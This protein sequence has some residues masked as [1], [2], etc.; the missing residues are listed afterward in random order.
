MSDKMRLMTS[1]A[2]LVLGL[3]L[4][5]VAHAQDI[6]PQSAQTDTDEQGSSEIVVSGLRA[7]LQS[8]ASTK[9]NSNQIQDSILAEDIGK[10]PDTNIAETLQRIPGV[11]ISRNTRGEGNS[12]VIHGLKQVMTTVN[13]RQLFG[14][15]NRTA[16]LLDYSAD[17][18]SGVDVYKTATS[19]QIEGGLGG[20]VNI[21]TARPFDFDGMHVA[22]TGSLAYS[23]FQDKV[24]PRISGVVS[25]RW[26][27]GGG[28]FG[29]LVGGQYERY[30]SG[31][32]QSSTNGYSDNVNLFDVDES[33]ATGTAGDVVTV[34]GQVRMRYETG[35]R[36]R[37]ALYG[38]AQWAPNDALTIHADAI[39]TYSGGHSFT[40][41]MAVNNSGATGVGDPVFK[42]GSTVLS[43]YSLSNVGIQ[44]AVGAADNPYDTIN[45]ALG[46]TYQSGPWTISAE[47]SYVRSEGPFYYRNGALSGRAPGADISLD[48]DTPNV[49]V[50][51]ID[52][53]DP[54]SYTSSSY[55][56]YGTQQL[57]R[58]PSFRAD[59]A[60]D[61]D[62]GPI[63][64]LM[65]GV[66]WAEHRAI[67]D[68]YFVNGG[69]ITQSISDVTGPTP[70][71][72]FTNQTAWLNQWLS[73]DDGIFKDA[74]QAR[75][76]FGLASAD[77]AVSA[78]SHYDYTETT[79]AAY[80]QAQYALNLGGLPI[81]GNI[82][83]RYVRTDG[84]QTVLVQNDEGDYEPLSGGS[85]YEDWLPSVNM[86]LK[87]TPDLF[88]RLAFSKAITRPDYG[89]LS[90][91]VLLNP[92]SLTGSGGNTELL[93]T[94]ADQYDLSLEYYF[95][96]L[97]YLS[98]GLFQKDVSGFIQKFYEDET[99]DG[100]VYQITRPR[101]SG[102]GRIRGFEIAYQQFFDFL[103]GMLSGLGFQGNYTY[104]DS[105]LEQYGIPGTVPA[106]Q[107]SKHAY[108]LTGIYEKG[109]VSLHVS[110]NWRSKSVQTNS[111]A[112]NG[113]VWNAPQESLDISGTFYLTD[114]LSVKV[115][116]VNA[117]AAY[118][119][120][121][122]GTP[123]RPSLANQLDR[124][125]QIGFHVNF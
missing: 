73:F 12:Y 28:E 108:N 120:Q 74:A 70:G 79:T 104:V 110:Y 85:P 62:N 45:L 60:Y 56:E 93:P 115:D 94:K 66:R 16:L 18:L 11:Q 106:D 34:P 29:L 9:R 61:L 64:K 90:P 40:Q 24:G 2:V 38:A 41:Q 1:T 84:V 7:S 50:D 14:T 67:Y 75:A 37:S 68:F 33:G 122:Y 44:S 4:A 123:D 51:G 30:Y 23:E 69:A 39:Y 81:D 63:T 119:N 31:G 109:P 13:G 117:T 43:N 27:L 112:V 46:G 19:D 107:L 55:Y 52:L 76:L 10:L 57:G 58:E 86:R 35:D 89:N 42:S 47:A 88:L 87:F 8:T 97:N 96:T 25:N 53:N 113:T 80:V 121:Y 3:A 114:W 49:G 116:V 6:D 98:V 17:I 21:H 99:I 32:Y 22:A 124:T 111:A 118:Q 48:G 26:A 71:N 82:G 95:G 65:A 92:A 20:L 91:A 15:T 125:Y 59:I 36:V 54:A 105:E 77:P 72:L 102:E 83:L 5:P 100:E 78:G 101:N 103:P